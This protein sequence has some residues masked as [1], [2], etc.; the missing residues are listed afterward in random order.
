MAEK[1]KDE[2]VHCITGSLLKIFHDVIEKYN[3]RV[4]QGALVTLQGIEYKVYLNQV[5]QNC[6]VIKE[7]KKY[8]QFPVFYVDYKT[9]EVE[10]I[11][12]PKDPV[13]LT[14][15]RIL[16]HAQIVEEGI[17]VKNYRF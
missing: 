5:R 10:W 6:L 1:Q 15:D 8:E 17:F 11:E 16:D 4:S 7:K 13:P 3:L 9:G 12:M 2:G 14:L